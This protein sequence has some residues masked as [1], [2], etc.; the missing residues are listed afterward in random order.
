MAYQNSRENAYFEPDYSHDLAL[1]SNIFQHIPKAPYLRLSL[2][3]FK[4]IWP[5]IPTSGASPQC[6][7]SSAAYIPMANEFRQNCSK[8]LW[9]ASRY[10]GEVRT[11]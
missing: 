6:F 8:I 2:K 3:M 11:T 7:C 1:T 9:I 10:S 5:P 4:G